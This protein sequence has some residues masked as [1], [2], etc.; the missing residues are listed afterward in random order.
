MEGTYLAWV[1]VHKTGKTADALVDE[2]MEKA[3]VKLNSGTMYGAA[4]GDEFVR[5][6][7]ACPRSQLQE[8][9]R[10]I[11]EKMGR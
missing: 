1:D 7:L 3:H 9:L 2:V 6:N 5:I 10:R 8:A 11:A 4:P